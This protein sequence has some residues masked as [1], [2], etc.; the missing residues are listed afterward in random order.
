MLYCTVNTY[1]LHYT[2]IQYK[3]NNGLTKPWAFSLSSETRLLASSNAMGTTCSTSDW[4]LYKSH[5]KIS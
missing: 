1:T 4:T 3:I 5:R 2:Y